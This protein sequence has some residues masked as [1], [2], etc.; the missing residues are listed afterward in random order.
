MGYCTVTDIDGVLAQALTSA[1]DPQNNSRRDLL[2]IGRVR[3]KNVVSDSVVR[4]YIRWAGHEIDATLSQQYATPI[5]QIADFE[6]TLFSDVSEY[7]SYIVLEKDCPLATGDVVLLISSDIEEIHTVDEMLG[8]GLFST[9]EPIQYEFPSGS[10]IIR[11]KYPDPLP[12]ICARL[13]AANIYEKYFAAQVGPQSSEYG[14]LLRNLGRQKLNDVLNGRA[15][16]HGVHRIGSRFY[17]PTLT[18][19]YG[20]HEGDSQR[21]IDRLNG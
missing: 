3:D 15:I 5:C 20:L 11:I 12:W 18:S 10:R 17:D 21:D 1:T 6:S 8:E 16:L 2:Q 4:D 9:L 19:Q 7:N 13:A 14:T